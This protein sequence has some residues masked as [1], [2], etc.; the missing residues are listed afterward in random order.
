MEAATN[1]PVLTARIEPFTAGVL[2][3]LLPPLAGAAGVLLS[4][5]Q[6][7]ALR[8]GDQW[9][10]EPVPFWALRAATD[11]GFLFVDREGGATRVDASGTHTT[12]G[13]TSGPD[14][15][16][17]RAA[18]AWDPVRETLVVFG[19]AVGKR[20]VADTW[21]WHEGTW[22]R[23]KVTSK[24]AARAYAQMAWVPSLG[25]MLVTGGFAK[26][27]HFYDLALYRQ[28]AWEV[29]EHPP[30]SDTL[31]AAVLV[32]SDA[33]SGHLIQAY[34]M[35]SPRGLG[36]WR[37]AGGNRWELAGRVV[38]PSMSEEL[39]GIFRT[40][41]FLFALDPTTRSLV[42]V[43]HDDALR[44]SIISVSLGAW[45]DALPEAVHHSTDAPRAAR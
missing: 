4:G 15:R 45:F 32:G 9:R 36:L 14:P 18:T 40:Q 12:P 23:V 17:S 43:G 37:H 31:L 1:V 6:G 5:T 41:D 34:W 7:H 28:G 44:P 24:P 2:G 3:A 35:T 30:F 8:V 20:A 25:G 29:W 22:R 16:L 13:R 38:F 33:R 26:L 27:S 10:F 11:D 19:G 21:E 39:A 42:G